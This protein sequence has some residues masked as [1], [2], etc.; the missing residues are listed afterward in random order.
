MPGTRV[1][2]SGKRAFSPRMDSSR[3]LHDAPDRSYVHKLERFAR[4]AEPELKRVF[5]GFA[6]PAG[7]VALDLGCGAGLATRWLRESVRAGYVVG[8]DLSL[9]HLQA[10]GAHHSPLV[11]VDGSRLGLR[12]GTFDFVW[13]CNTIN[14]LSNPIE[15]L[16]GLR[17]LL[18]PGG[19]LALAQSGFLPDM[20]FAWDAPLEDAV[21]AA[22]H[23][24]YRERYGLDLEDTAGIR[25]LVRLM[26]AAG[27]ES[28]A[29]RTHVVERMQPL[30]EAD[31]DYFRHA[32]FEGAW[33]PKVLPFLTP[34][35]RARLHRN[36]DPASPE[37]CLDRQDFHH[38]QTLTVCEGRIET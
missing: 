29:P 35:E 31:R 15:A 9:P 5:A 27:F 16:R 14:H 26:A 10:A 32:I 37:Y 23:R 3:P 34:D 20:F 19:R 11:Q 22:C 12:D 36:C 7:A 24:A 33:G 1:R 6:L 30:R 18:R 17:R 38:L 8:A 2:G 4:F 13:S 28:V 21:R 25:G